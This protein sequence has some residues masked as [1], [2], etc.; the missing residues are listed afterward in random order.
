MG[1]LVTQAFPATTDQS[2]VVQSIVEAN[3]AFSL[4]RWTIA[5]GV[6]VQ[7]RIDFEALD[8]AAAVS[9]SMEFT[10]ADPVRYFFAWTAR[11]LSFDPFRS[12][13]A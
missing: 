4:G 13:Y 5:S 1:L 3:K 9:E 6:V 7:L 12:S 8:R 11:G 10:V 2:V